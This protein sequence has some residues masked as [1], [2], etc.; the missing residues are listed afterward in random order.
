LQSFFAGHIVEG[1]P[2][3]CNR[4]L[5]TFAGAQSDGKMGRADLFRAFFNQTA[6]NRCFSDL[7]EHDS[8]GCFGVASPHE[9][10]GLISLPNVGW[11]RGRYDQSEIGA[12]H[13]RRG[14][15]V[16]EIGGACRK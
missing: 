4:V 1:L 16:V 6:Q 11:G 10:N 14:S 7:V 2:A 12:S 5:V 15:G 3:L 8:H 13:C 9:L